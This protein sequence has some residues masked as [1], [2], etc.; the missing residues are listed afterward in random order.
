MSTTHSFAALILLALVSTSHGQFSAAFFQDEAYWG[1]GKAE[2]NTYEAQLVRYGQPRPSEVIHILV[3]EP[4]SNRELVKAEPGS[5]GGSYPVIKLNQILRIPTGVYVYQQMHSAFWRTDSGRLVKATLTSNDSC[6]NT[7]KEF[8]AL[9]GPMAWFGGGWRYEW[10]TYWEGASAG[11]ETI[12]AAGDAIFYDELPVRVRTIDF[13]GGSGEFVVSMAPTIIGSKKGEVKFSPATV[14]WVTGAQAI[15]VEVAHAAG[16]D[17]FSLD[18]KAPHF[19]REW[20]QADGGRLTLRRSVK[21]DYWNYNKVGDAE[22]AFAK[23]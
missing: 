6:G 20:Q 15:T 5:S 1:D 17:R 7:Y 14:K 4:F 10:R 18:G 3:R 8:R 19:L 9:T 22:R 16:M 11:A 23:P 2:F 21:L 13:G 12:R